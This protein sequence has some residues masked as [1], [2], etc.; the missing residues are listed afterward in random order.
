M[1][2]AARSYDRILDWSARARWRTWFL[3]IRD[4]YTGGSARQAPLTP[5]NNLFLPL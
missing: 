5:I 1:A 4:F 3:I 2:V